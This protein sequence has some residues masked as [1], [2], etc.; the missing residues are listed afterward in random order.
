[1][2]R[3][4][5]DVGT[6]KR[7]AARDHEKAALVDLSNLIDKPVAF[8]CRKFIIPAGGFRRRIEITM[9]ALKIAALR[10]IQRNEIGLEVIDCPA[11]VRPR[12]RGWR[13]KEMRHLLL[14]TAE[15]ADERRGTE[16]RK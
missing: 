7:F 11:V 12:G 8:F 16:H 1:M 15:R 4:F 9:V 2:P 14:D 6:D 13:G 3:D 5:E 10:E